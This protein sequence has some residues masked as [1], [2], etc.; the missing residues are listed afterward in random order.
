[1]PFEDFKEMILSKSC[2]GKTLGI[3]NKEQDYKLK[4]SPNPTS[5]YI[6]IQV[7]KNL[8]SSFEI[9]D[10]NE[11]SVKKSTGVR[12]QLLTIDSTSIKKGIYFVQIITDSG[13]I[14]KKK[15]V[16]Q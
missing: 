9:F 15:I 1:M 8:I 5:N 7:D 13:L 2:A 6:N 14:F 4:I 16:F 10:S 12:K 3:Q 11:T